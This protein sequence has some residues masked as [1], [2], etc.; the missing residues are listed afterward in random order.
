MNYTGK[1]G[2]NISRLSQTVRPW[3]T[4]K[5]SRRLSKY[6]RNRGSYRQEVDC[7]GK[8]WSSR[9]GISHPISIISNGSALA[10]QKVFATFVQISQEPRQLQTRGRLFWKDLVKPVRNQSSDLD[11]LKRSGFYGQKTESQVTY[12]KAVS[13]GPKSWPQE[14]SKSGKRSCFFKV[15]LSFEYSL[16]I[17]CGFEEIRAGH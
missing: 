1:W 9:F 14:D 5:C 16:E 10:D 8:T 11:Y 2:F 7:F 12:L 6:L 4:R 3:R 13:C 17:C 15:F